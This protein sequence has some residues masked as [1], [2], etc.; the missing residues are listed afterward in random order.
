[1]HKI[2]FILA[3]CCLG[4]GI[5]GQPNINRV[6]YFIDTD[7]GFGSGTSLTI[8]PAPDL[9]NVNGAVSLNGVS[10]GIHT[11]FIRSRDANGKWSVTNRFIFVLLS[12]TAASP[13]INKAEYFFD[14]DPGF[15]N[16]V[17]IPL[18][19]A[20]DISNMPVAIPMNNIS[21]G[22]HTLYI[23]SR[24]AASKWSLTNHFLFVKL[25]ANQNSN[26]VAAEYYI[27]N[28]P[29]FGSGTTIPIT[30]G[31]DLQNIAAQISL[32]N[33]N[34]G[35]HKLFLRTKD[36]NG[37]W[38]VTNERLFVKIA[39]NNP[40][41]RIEYFYDTDPGFGNAVPIVINPLP[42]IADYVSPV[43]ITGLG[44]G[45]HRIFI[46]SMNE[47]GKWSITN[48]D[49]FTINTPAPDPFINVNSITAKNLCGDQ[50]FKLSFHV[51]GTYNNGNIFSVQLSDANGGFTSPSTIG[52][53]T[54]TVSSIVNCT[55]PLHIPNGSGYKVRVVS[56]SPVV[57]GVQS[58]TAFTLFDQPRY[59][60]TSVFVVCQHDKFNLL[61]VYNTS[62][63]TLT[64][65][66]GTPSATPIGN[67]QM[68]TQ[69]TSKCKDTAVIIVKQDV[70]KWTGATSKNWH[71]ASNWSINRV[72]GVATHVIV[73]AG[74]PN[75][76]EL[77]Q[78]NVTI[79]SVQVR[80][81]AILNV[82]NSRQVSIT[83]NCSPLPQN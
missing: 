52:S 73:E 15:G 30:P 28:D 2:I 82:I 53:I 75:I 7:P 34:E 59:A 27:D 16:A 48:K 38:S 20:Q 81:G 14:T 64:W 19:A 36:A 22:M 23:R 37:K 5:I 29:G 71:T 41:T 67:Y 39:V 17:N 32:A 61:N 26:V 25:T 24:D 69:N 43:N 45:K 3:C 80:P 63:Y 62:A 31:N 56:S 13:N 4:T 57:T 77:S 10:T 54:A 49:S 72:P 18:T 83:A 76:C 65:N 47:A 42:D 44:G 11:L 8:S 12:P 60:D 33:I 35:L 51:T 78:S 55:I 66:T 6:E 46:R 50:S 21:E 40:V 9:Q 68:Y 74:T 79:S 1:M 70:A 58:D